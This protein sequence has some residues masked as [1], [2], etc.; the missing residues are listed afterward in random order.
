[1]RLTVNKRTF[2]DNFLHPLSVLVNDSMVYFE[3]DPQN[4]SLICICQHSN[5][6]LACCNRYFYTEFEQPADFALRDLQRLIKAIEFIDK[7]QEQITLVFENDIAYYEDAAIRFEMSVM[8][9]SLAKQFRIGLNTSLFD[10]F[11]FDIDFMLPRSSIEQLI[12]ARQFATDADVLQFI[13]DKQG[14]VF[15]ELYKHKAPKCDRIKLKIADQSD[16]KF[17]KAWTVPLDL[18]SVV[19]SLRSDMRVMSKSKKG[20]FLLSTQF[21]D[22]NVKYGQVPIE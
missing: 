3:H 6:T 14:Q 17:D 15:C 18:I 5:Q 22:C 4:K 7:A 21:Q 10:N 11:E 20:H 19:G 12:K 2:V 8:E 13:Q 1:M 9:E 16:G